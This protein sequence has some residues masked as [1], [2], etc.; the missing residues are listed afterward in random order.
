MKNSYPLK[1]SAPANIVEP[2]V[3]YLEQND[4]P[5]SALGIRDSLSQI[6]QLR[7]KACTLEL[8]SNPTIEV[9]DK[10]IAIIEMYVRY[11][12][13]I[14]KHFNWNPELGKTVE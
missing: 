10:Y 6:N 1:K 9:V 2:L 4:S 7:N 13:L 11:C 12:R 14:S 3:R 8:P 5:G